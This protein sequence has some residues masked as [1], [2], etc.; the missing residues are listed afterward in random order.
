ML[1]RL[2]GWHLAGQCLHT[3]GPPAVLCSDA[4]LGELR[5]RSL[6][7]HR[8]LSAK[9][10][11][12]PVGVCVTGRGMGEMGGGRVSALSHPRPETSWQP[13]DKALL[14]PCRTSF[15]MLRGVGVGP[16]WPPLLGVEAVIHLPHLPGRR[17][18]SE[19]SAP[20]W[21]PSFPPGLQAPGSCPFHFGDTWARKHV[22][23]FL[24][25]DLD[26]KSAVTSSPLLPR[27]LSPEAVPPAR[28]AQEEEPKAAHSPRAW[29][30]RETE[31]NSEQSTG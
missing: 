21:P 29:G 7:T 20:I 9:A 10:V 5:A 30:L 31:E 27:G 6:A 13:H 16:S 8:T 28:A 17:S 11:L 15:L 2:V 14:Q 1:P 26:V 12:E 19:G 24:R 18:W 25:S 4:G 23:S 3:Q 22:P